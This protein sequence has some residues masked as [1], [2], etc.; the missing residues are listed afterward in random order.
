MRYALPPGTIVSTQAWSMHRDAAVFPSPEMFLPERWL[1]SYAAGSKEDG[2]VG[3]GEAGAVRMAS[4][5]M[6]F[7]TGSRICGG[8]NLAHIIMRVVLVAVLRW[9]PLEIEA[10]I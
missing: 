8:V 5:M 7:G 3:G 1:P 6:P 4:P 2:G 10:W 9:Q